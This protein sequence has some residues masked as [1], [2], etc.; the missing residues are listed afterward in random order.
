MAEPVTSREC[1]C[2][3]LDKI[4]SDLIRTRAMLLQREREIAGLRAELGMQP[5]TGEIRPLAE[6]ER[7]AIMNAVVTRGVAEAAKLLG[8]GKTTLYRKMQEYGMPVKP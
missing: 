7:E 3:R 1:A 5:G 8:V 2:R 4:E 6:V